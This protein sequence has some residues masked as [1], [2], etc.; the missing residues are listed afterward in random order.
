MVVMKKD[1]NVEEGTTEKIKEATIMRMTK[2]DLAPKSKQNM[3]MTLQRHTKHGS[4]AR[5]QPS[6]LLTTLAD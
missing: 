2:G 4:M 3:E 5:D 6:N 1:Q